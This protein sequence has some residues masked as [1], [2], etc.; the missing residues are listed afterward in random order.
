MNCKY[1]GAA[2][3]TSG[4]VCPSCGKMIPISQQKEMKK[5]LDP[6]WNQYR[7]KNTA[8]YKQASNTDNDAKIGKAIMLIIGVILFIIIIAIIKG[9]GT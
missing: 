7:N 6:R 5:I 9:L 4:G 2:L 1:C 8:L 3:P